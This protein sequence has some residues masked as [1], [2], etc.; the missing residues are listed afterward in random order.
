MDFKARMGLDYS[1][2]IQ[3]F[4]R[5]SAAAN[6]SCAKLSASISSF[7]KQPMKDAEKATDEFAK[8]AEKNFKSVSRVV[9]GIL[10]SQAF[11]RLISL[12]RD[13][14]RELYNF[15]KAA[16]TASISFAV[17]LDNE[18][19][20]RRFLNV[21]ED[22][23]AVTPFTMGETRSA[24]Q[25]MMA[26]G[27]RPENTLTILRSTLNA[28]TAMGG[29][30]QTIENITFALGKI[31]T[32]GR[33]TQRQLNSLA[34]NGIPAYKIL[35]EKLNLT[36][37]QLINIGKL[38][39]PA[40][41]AIKA[42][43]KGMNE[44][45]YN[46]SQLVATTVQG[47]SSTIY[48]DLLL[49]FKDVT[50]GPYAKWRNFLHGIVIEL[51]HIRRIARNTGIGGVFEH[52]VPKELQPQI[53]LLL[54][55]IQIFARSVQEVFYQLNPFITAFG[56]QFV[57]VLNA[58]FPI[59]NMFM[60]T[61]LFLSSIINYNSTAVRIFVSV[62]S[63]FIIL[64]VLIG[65]VLGFAKALKALLIVQIVTRALY[66]LIKALVVVTTFMFANPWLFLITAIAAG[67]MIAAFN[68]RAFQ[69][70]LDSLGNT[71]NKMMG[72]DSS[73]ILKPAVSK[74]AKA[75]Q[76]E[77][78]QA[79]GDTS[80][81]MDDVGDSADKAKKKVNNLLASFD[82]VY[83]LAEN[84]DDKEGLADIL[85]EETLQ[86]LNMPDVPK[87]ADIKVP[88]FIPSMDTGLFSKWWK[89][90]MTKLK[91]AMLTLT[92]VDSA[93]KIWNLLPLWW[94]SF[95][96]WLESLWIDLSKA[97]NIFVSAFGRV[98]SEMWEANKAVILAVYDFITGVQKKITDLYLNVAASVVNWTMN[99]LTAIGG[100]VVDASGKI[101]DW[102][103]KTYSEIK[104]WSIDSAKEIVDW[105]AKTAPNFANWIVDTGRNIANWA[106]QTKQ[107]VAEWKNK[108]V[109]YI[110]DIAPEIKTKVLDWTRSTATYISTWKT[111]TISYIS[112][113][114]TTATGKF[115]TF[116]S[117]VKNGFSNFG[118]DVY[119]SVVG[120]FDRMWQKVANVLNKFPKISLSSSGIDFSF[121]T[122]AIVG[123]ASG[124]VMSREHFAKIAEG[125]KPEMI[126]PTANP[127]DT[128]KIVA[129]ML[130]NGLRAA[131]YEI[132]ASMPQGSSV[133][134]QVMQVGTLIADE[135]SLKELKRKMDV[136]KLNDDTRL[137]LVGGING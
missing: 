23:A 75:D 11:Y 77:F 70:S 126:V 31:N 92:P 81:G 67:L 119:N 111:N 128:A 53:R 132:V 90:S 125:N 54:S 97:W 28:A 60:R 37:D 45:Y 83:N 43:V 4:Q 25:R 134:T 10:I 76:D 9:S 44:R 50:A 30:T 72:V 100:W 15:Q 88:S 107:E 71:I 105:V 114:Y 41:I 29:D 89:E 14:T 122:S 63:T 65:L 79:L 6:A 17:L 5:A 8:S 57:Q 93:I 86:A 39:V 19:R 98:F 96:L 120:W 27:I 94:K 16:E 116:W 26:M 66:E 33:V 80:D 21:L 104:K 48:D 117:T 62:L 68:T 59:I 61:L 131:M 103:S 136:I 78:N 129:A 36:R 118:R 64:R 112:S 135:R 106:K 108:V 51:E 123:H 110:V 85:D 58:I 121:T 7:V 22:F 102:S 109:K 99:T 18:P 74:N 35:A 2:F 87:T 32:M 20:A 133:P 38:R 56:T 82:E 101:A 24:A 3:G 130:D 13:A 55:N 127:N 113:W 40:D 12:M 49:I 47:L 84:K 137:G 115:T 124:G 42:L 69:Q 1:N 91:D 46:L 52:I 73:K 34:L 95:K